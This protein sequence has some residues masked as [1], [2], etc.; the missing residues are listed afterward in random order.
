MK[1][2]IAILLLLAG[3]A[4]GQVIE[5]NLDTGIILLPVKDAATHEMLRASLRDHDPLVRIQGLVALA[6]IRD[7]AD[8]PAIRALLTDPVA[9][10]R[11]QAGQQSPPA[12]VPLAA[13]AAPADWLSSSNVLYRQVAVDA[14][15][16]R[17][18]A[19]LAPALPALLDTPDS[20]LRR[21]VCEA[22]GH[23]H[24]GQSA[25]LAAQLARDDDPFVRRAAAEAL[26]A[27]HTEA[28]ESALISLLKH[29]SAPVRLE[30]ARA[31]G[32]WAQPA[33]AVSLHALLAD[34]APTVA[35]TAA[36]AVGKLANPESQQPL[37][38]QFP[39][40]P[41]MV[42]E[43]MAWALGEFKTPAAVPVLLPMLKTGYET[44]EASST[45]ALGKIG[46]KQAIPELRK[47]LVDMKTHGSI[48]RQRAIEAL[49]RLGD[50]ESTK[51]VLQFVTEKVVP[52][53]PGVSEWSLDS[54]DV[55]AEALR[56]LAF[57]GDARLADEFMS[58]LKDLPSW[59]LRQV[60]IAT[61]TQL[62]GKAY[63]AE[64]SVDARHYLLESL[65]GEF[66]PQSPAVPGV[67]EIPHR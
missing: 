5:T 19:E 20:V 12:A 53:P 8:A 44:V 15:A 34:A 16:R 51:R 39:K 59:Q 21:H 29:D 64:F 1:R 2:T 17:Q 11:D 60:L 9:A 24:A 63:R 6:T 50:R 41:V 58:K 56:Y 7:P 48:T 57:I 49:R 55:R 26:L 47:V 67:V 10:V 22:L 37:L 4:V 13:P 23:L 66:Y 31:L 43:R 3:H 28:A 36:E 38:N 54:D 32:N 30:A 61:L 33:V 40:S 65:A 14:V 42:Q 62:T 25:A 52:P 46:D 45:E 35:R 18:L 27:L